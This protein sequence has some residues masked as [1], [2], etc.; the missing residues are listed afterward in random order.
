M[1]NI[2]I[3]TLSVLVLFIVFDGKAQLV[4]PFT[5][6]TSPSNPGVTIYNLKGDFTMIGNTNLTLQNYGDNTG[7]NNSMVFVDIDGDASTLNSSSSYLSLSGG[8]G[9]SAQCS[10]VVY[11]GLYWTGRA[12]NGT[13][14]PNEFS[15]TKGGITSVLNKQ[16]VKI[17]GPNA[18]N[19]STITATSTDIYYPENSEGFMYSSYAEVTQ[20]V[21]NNGTEGLYTIA[22]IALNE[23]NGGGTGFYGG[24][25]MVVIYGNSSMAL[26]DI[27]VFDGHAYVAGNITA[28]FTIP[29]SGFNSTQSGPVNVKMGMMAGEGDRTI[30]GDYFQIRDAANTSWVNLNH[31]GNS[32]NNFF[33]SSISTGGNT[34]VPNLL[35]NTGLDICMFN[36]P[37]ANN[38]IITNNQSS[39]TFRYGTTQDTYIIYSIVF[40]VD[41]YQPDIV[42]INTLETVNNVPATSSPTVEPGEEMGYTLE[43]FNY[44]NEPIE[45]GQV[46]IPIP[47][48]ANFVNAS[49]TFLFTPNSNSTSYFD[50]T[51]GANG[52]IVWNVGNLPVPSSQNTVL[53]QLNYTLSATEDCFLLANTTCDNVIEVNGTITGIGSI[54]GTSLSKTFISGFEETGNCAGSPITQPLEIPIIGEQF[55]KENCGD[56]QTSYSFVFCGLG[57][58]PVIQTNQ[59]SGSFPVGTRFFDSNPVTTTSIE[60]TITGFPTISGTTSYYAYPQ[61]TESSCSI[62]LNITVIDSVITTVPSANDVVYCLNE[63]AVPLT[64]TPSNNENSV[65]YYSQF[66]GG[67]PNGQIIPSTTI[68]GNFTYYAVEAISNNCISSSSTPIN[69]TVYSPG[70]ATLSGVNGSDE[71]TA[72][73]TAGTEL[74]FALFVENAQANQPLTLSYNDAIEGATFTAAENGLSGTFCWAPSNTISGSYT[75]EVAVSD[76][77]GGLQSYSYE[78]IVESSPCDVVVSVDNYSNITCSDNDGSAQITATGGVAPYTYTVINNSTGEVFSNTSGTFTDLT[79][80]EYSVFVTDANSCQP[81]CSNLNFEVSGTFSP[82]STEI[83]A[84][85]DPC[86]LNG[87][88]GGSI[89]INTQGG[90]PGYLYSI[91][92]GFQSDNVFNG[93]SSGNYS[94]NIIDANGCSYNTTAI[95]SSSTP[96]NLTVSNVIA[97]NCGLNTGSLTIAVNGGNAPYA[98]EMNGQQVNQGTTQNLGAGQYLIT[99]SDVNNCTSSETVLISSP[100]SLSTSIINVVQPNCLV[101]L[102]SF[103]VGV[104]GGTGPYTFAMG[105]TESTNNTFNNLSAGNYTLVTTDANGCQSISN[106]E[107]MEPVNLSAQIEDLTDATCGLSNGGFTVNILEGTAPFTYTL[108]SASIEGPIFNDLSEGDYTLIVTDANLCS[109]SLI[110]SINGTPAFTIS[111]TA[112]SSTCNGAC[113][114]SIVLSSSEENVNYSW[115]NGQTGSQ[116]ENLCAGTYEVEAINENGCTQELTLSISE[117]PVLT[118][119]LSETSNADCNENNGSAVLI[120]QGGTAPYLYSIAGSSQSSVISNNTGNFNNLSVGSYAYYVTDSNNCQIE[121]VQLFFI[122]DDCAGQNSVG[123]NR[124]ISATNQTQLLVSSNTEKNS[125]LVNYSVDFEDGM[126]MIFMD[127]SGRVIQEIILNKASGKFEITG[128]APEKKCNF[129]IIENQKGKIISSSKVK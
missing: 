105:N 67:S 117:P 94:I 24:W 103:E 72:T 102:G 66:P 121:C 92:N 124:Q 62:E 125:Y 15:V 84:T 87:S 68:A 13:N 59:I 20:Y 65:Y 69:V 6:R 90:T 14:S 79:V 22:D 7:N 88:N 5:Q 70:T 31:S 1:K 29:V 37:N 41:A 81:I 63:V 52:S 9:G 18:S 78:I 95:V 109:Q 61:G 107:I 49:G 64:A 21:Q 115:S 104:S 32:S 28:D 91:G 99:V 43:I 118:L 76:N 100:T 86:A 106:V 119:T 116:L 75:F 74:C 85:N 34:R 82:I 93:L 35:N 128:I 2:L 45:N 27:T 114:G 44:G 96:L 108:N 19:Y 55:V 127:Q 48:N 25:G 46:I 50:P 42:G 110:V 122:T 33:N 120:A 39:T 77:C 12:H 71:Y 17:K 8:N 54:T 101:T 112:N 73:V 16:I 47:Y 89:T 51:V 38:S 58:S 97:D 4:K 26:R 111:A 126:K 10:E 3:Q 30:S 98:I 129:V 80:G 36:I 56:I 11:A 23:G 53:G 60:Y 83:D 113:D 123:G 40:A 57:S